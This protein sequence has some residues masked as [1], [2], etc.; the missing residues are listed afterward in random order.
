MN[1]ANLLLLLILL[2]FMG[3]ALAAMLPRNARN[4]EAWLSGGVTVAAFAIGA[5][6]FPRVSW[7]GTMSNGCRSSASTSRCAWTA[8][9]GC[10]RC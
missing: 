8:S 10:S 2:P 3:S 5:S 6:M 9:P 7:C 1:D 4:G